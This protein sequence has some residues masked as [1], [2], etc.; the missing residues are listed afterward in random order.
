[1]TA[2]EANAMMYVA[3]KINDIIQPTCE[4]TCEAILLDAGAFENVL[5]AD[6]DIGQHLCLGEIYMVITC[7]NGYKYY[8]NVT[9]D[10]ILAAFAEVFDLIQYKLRAKLTEGAWQ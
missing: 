1:M 3:K 5:N 6:R 10:S 2:N 4:A 8:V 7:E 9:G